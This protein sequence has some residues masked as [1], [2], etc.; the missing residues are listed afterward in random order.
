MI[1]QTLVNYPIRYEH[2]IV[3]SLHAI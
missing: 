2:W 3:N 1:T